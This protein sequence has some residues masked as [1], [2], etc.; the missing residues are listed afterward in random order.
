MF[1]FITISYNHEKYIIEHL[2][3]IKYQ[4]QNYGNNKKIQLIISDDSS[5]DKTIELAKKW[6]NIN[7]ELFSN[8]K[9]LTSK[10]NQGI[11]KNYLRGISHVEYGEYKSLAGDDLY[12]KNNIFEVLKNNDLVFTP[13]ITFDNDKITN[14]NSMSFLIKN[15]KKS[16]ISKILKYGNSISAPGVFIKLGLIKDNEM[17]NFISQFKWI[18]DLPKWYYI[19]NIRKEELNY[20]LVKNPYIMYRT[21]SGISRTKDNPKNKEFLNERKKMHE[22][23]GMKLEKYPKYVNPYRYY[24]KLVNLKHIY[25]DMKFNS[26]IVEFNRIMHEEIDQASSYLDYIKSKAYEFYES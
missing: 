21:T 19:F 10:N 1:T 2:E 7:N 22:Q 9:V 15:S 14:D 16:Q 6:L 18:E 4:I 12:Y 13:T 11:V 17:Q 20:T 23:F 5:E 3:S 8:I 26:E 24:W 25:Y